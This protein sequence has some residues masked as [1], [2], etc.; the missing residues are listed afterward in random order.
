MQHKGHQRS[1]CCEGQNAI[2]QIVHLEEADT[3]HQRGEHTISRAEAIHAVDKVDGVDDSDGRDERKGASD[4]LGELIDLPQAVEVVDIDITHKHHNAHNEDL[5]RKAELRREI[6]N[7]VAHAGVEHNEHSDDQL[8][9]Q[10]DRGQII[11]RGAEAEHQAKEY[12][13]TAQDGHRNLVKFAR[14]G[15]IDDVLQVRNLN[16]IGLDDQYRYGSH[17]KRQ[18]RNI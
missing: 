11:S 6:Q 13:H 2:W 17:Q 8:E 3:E 15:I 12:A 1:E 18:N 9:L 14:I 10:A 4:D 5:H 16:Q 7:I